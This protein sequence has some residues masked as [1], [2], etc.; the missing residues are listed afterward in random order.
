M[1]VDII[2]NIKLNYPQFTKAEKKVADFILNNT[3]KVIFMSITD[4]AYACKVGDTS[5][6]RFCRTMKLQGY[7]EF[8]MKLSLSMNNHDDIELSTGSMPVNLEDSFNILTQ[9]ILQNNIS[10]INETYSL[11]KPE[12]IARAMYYFEKAEH[13]YFFGVGASM[14]TAL[15]AANKFLRITP[16]VQCIQD[17]HMQ[18]MLASM[19]TE[20]D[21]AFVISYSGATKDT[22][23]VAKLAKN[24][25]AKVVCITRHENSP[26]TT[27]SDVTI[28]CG[29]NE[30]PLEGGST[31]AQ[32][33]QLFLIDILYM[34]YYKK[35]YEISNINNQRTSS[36][37]LD[38][39]Y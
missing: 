29:S 35:K 39:I 24:Q 23:H 10:A 33:S 36:A 37:V 2:E 26:L 11:L 1:S 6:F 19:L 4:L 34:E 21:L 8:K 3:K 12:E 5:V 15:V 32:M 28:L 18:A 31:S 30:G 9:K 27:Y 25:G 14:I 38:K 20:K 17:S 7:Q 13:V 22:I 16:N